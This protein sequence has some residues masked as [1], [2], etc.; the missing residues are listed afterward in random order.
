MSML[1]NIKIISLIS[2]E[3]STVQFVLFEIPMC[4]AVFVVKLLHEGS[5]QFGAKKAWGKVMFTPSA[6]RL[7]ISL[8]M[9]MV[10]KIMV[11]LRTI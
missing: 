4:S 10:V 6:F 11:E 8:Q 1:G 3:H 2:V 5:S 9:V 7:L